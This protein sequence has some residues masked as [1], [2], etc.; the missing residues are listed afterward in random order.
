MRTNE[1][2]SELKLETLNLHPRIRLQVKSM[3][4]VTIF[5]NNNERDNASAS[6][7]PP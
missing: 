2:S 1:N 4:S 7:T 3:L 6:I 5:H